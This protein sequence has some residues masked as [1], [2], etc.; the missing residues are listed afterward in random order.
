MRAD[1]V[2][3][4]ASVRSLLM[5]IGLGGTVGFP[6]HARRDLLGRCRS[7]EGA[8]VIDASGTVSLGKR[9]ADRK[10]HGERVGW[11]MSIADGGKG[12]D[13]S[14]FLDL[15]VTRSA[16]GH[17][18]GIALAKAISFHKLGFR[19]CGNQLVVSVSLKGIDAE[20]WPEEKRKVA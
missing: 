19:G 20:S 1:Y 9:D 3:V 14:Q 13:W 16:D 15:D 4:L 8:R 17:G 11:R 10:R 2:D 7:A 6:P 12:F 18:R 5:K